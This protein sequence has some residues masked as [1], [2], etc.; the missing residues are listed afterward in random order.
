MAFTLSDLAI[1]IVE[2]TGNVNLKIS[3]ILPDEIILLIVCANESNVCMSFNNFLW[4][5]VV[6]LVATTGCILIIL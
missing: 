4:K 5:F 6:F 1:L 2:T 3:R